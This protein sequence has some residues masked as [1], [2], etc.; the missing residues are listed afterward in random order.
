[1]C[2]RASLFSDLV[3][4]H[5]ISREVCVLVDV[6]VGLQVSLVVSV[7]GSADAGEDSLDAEH[8]RDV[9][10]LEQHALRRENHRLDAEE[11]QRRATRLHRR[12]AREGSEKVTAGLG[13]PVGI[14]DRDLLVAGDLKVPAP[15]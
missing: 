8:A 9:V 4:V 15:R 2:A 13:L 5:T 11:R 6:H 7:D 10:A 14:D 1:M 12:R 3:A